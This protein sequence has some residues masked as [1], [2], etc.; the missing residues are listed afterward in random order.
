MSHTPGP[1][2]L[3]N[4]HVIRVCVGDCCAP[5]ADLRSPYRH[6]VGIVRAE[7]EQQANARLIAAAPELLGALVRTRDLLLHKG[8]AFATADRAIAKATGGA[9]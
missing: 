3:F 7:V 5:I 1:W 8:T 6:R 2:E 4:G 9:A